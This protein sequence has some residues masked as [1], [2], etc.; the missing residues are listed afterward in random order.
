MH[1]FEDLDWTSANGTALY[2]TGVSPE[3]ITGVLNKAPYSMYK[4]TN[5]DTWTNWQGKWGEQGWIP[6]WSGGPPSPGQQEKWINPVEWANTP[7]PSE[8][9]ASTHSPVNLHAYDQYGNHV[10]L[11]EAGEVELEIPGTY[12]YYPSYEDAE[13]IIIDNEEDLRFEIE[14][15]DLGEFDFTCARYISSENKEITVTYENIIITENTTSSLQFGTENPDYIM[16]IDLDGDGTVDEYKAPDSI[17]GLND[18]PVADANGPYTGNV[19]TP[20]TIN[21]SGSYDPDG[22]IIGYEWDLDDDGEFDDAAGEMVEYTWNEAYS[23][24]IT[25]KVTDDNLVTATDTTTANIS[26]AVGTPVTFNFVDQYGN[27]EG[28][29]EERVYVDG[30]G[31]Q[32]DDD[33]ITVD[34]GDTVYYR[35]YFKQGSGLY[36]PKLSQECTSGVTIDVPFH[37]LTTDFEDQ[38]GDLA[39]I[40]D[41]KVYLDHVGYRADGD[42][43]TVPLDSTVY[44]RAYFK[45]G[46]GLNGPKLSTGIDGSSG[47]LTIMFRQ[48]SFVVIDSVTQEPVNGAQVYVDHVG[49]IENSG[50]VIVP[51]E[52]T[53]YHKANVDTT[54]SDKT[55][56]E[57]DETWTECTYE[58]DGNGFSIP[59][60]E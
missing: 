46:S 27:L 13:Y 39:G 50:T 4:I 19:G 47:E 24:N 51:L 41:E 5:S 43:V 36:G 14:A 57:V 3:L 34:P 48:M 1:Y 58:W 44:H 22:T 2:P 54:W 23:G 17:T 40:G 32:E 16:E 45:E 20:V 29:G 21:G 52:C 49:Y 10:G 55:G 28:T 15:T 33:V 30:I 35:A 53:V 59:S 25:L 7:P 60:Y 31:Y 18:P 38:N 56:K 42:N 11:D 9:A 12:L 26:G 37:T 6:Y 8:Y